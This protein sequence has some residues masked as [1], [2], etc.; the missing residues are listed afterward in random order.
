[1]AGSRPRALAAIARHKHPR[2]LLRMAELPR[3]PQGKIMRRAIRAHLLAQYRL[4][5]G[6]HPQLEPR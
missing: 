6:P 4:L 5:D 1:M 3:N 2:A